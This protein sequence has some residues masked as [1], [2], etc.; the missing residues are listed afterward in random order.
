MWAFATVEAKNGLLMK[1]V[2]RSAVEIIGEFS[3]QESA[4]TVWAFIKLEREDEGL[5]TAVANRTLEILGEFDVQK[6]SNTVWAFAKVEVLGRRRGT[7][8]GRPTSTVHSQQ[9]AGVERGRKSKPRPDM[10]Q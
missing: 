7:E 3:A 2:A 6:L 8:K 1:A 4:N 10:R 9:G 5:V